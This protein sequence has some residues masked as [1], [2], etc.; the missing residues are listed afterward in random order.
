MTTILILGGYGY[1]GKLLAKHLL[2]ET[3]YSIIVAGRN[4]QKAYAFAEQLN[5][6]RA[7]ALCVDARE[8]SSLRPALQVR[9]LMPGCRTCDIS[10][11]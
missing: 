11:S 6:L 10:K 7:T 5:T 9:G 8:P 3:Q 1:T 4:I 2:K